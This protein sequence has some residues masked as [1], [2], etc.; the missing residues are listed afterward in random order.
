M[1]MLLSPKCVTIGYPNCLL[2]NQPPPPLLK[3][4]QRSATLEI[5]SLKREFQGV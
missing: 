3:P 1:L 5:T 2:T 4:L